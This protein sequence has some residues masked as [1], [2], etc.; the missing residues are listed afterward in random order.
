MKVR[1]RGIDRRRIAGRAGPDD[2]DLAVVLLRHRVNL[3]SLGPINST[4]LYSIFCTLRGRQRSHPSASP[5]EPEHMVEAERAAPAQQPVIA[6]EPAG[7]V[8]DDGVGAGKAGS[9]ARAEDRYRIEARRG[10]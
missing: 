6:E 7:R 10:R 2:Q 8:A 4:G 1:A 5:S 3:K 9:R